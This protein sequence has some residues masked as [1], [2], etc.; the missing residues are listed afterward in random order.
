MA[1]EDPRYMT[2]L[3]GEICRA[4]VPCVLLSGPPH[5]STNGSTVSPEDGPSR[6]QLGGRRGKSQTAH[7]HFAFALCVRHHRQFHD[8]AGPFAGWTKEQR[9][10][11]QDRCVRESRNR[12]AMQAPAPA[13]AA[14]SRTARKRVGAGWSVAGVRDWLRKEAPTRQAAVAD[15][16]TEL[17]NLIEEDTL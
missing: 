15:A 14:S 3:R 1:G 2:W 8:E 17:A 12:Y 4:P 10:E 13:T 16:Y 11:W 5:H 6:K 7:D 9:R